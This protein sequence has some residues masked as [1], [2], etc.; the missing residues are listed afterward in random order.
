M[1]KLRRFSISVA[2]RGRY[3]HC[4][5]SFQSQL[6]MPISR[7]REAFLGN[8]IQVRRKASVA[9]ATAR[10]LLAEAQPIWGL[11]SVVGF[12]MGTSGSQSSRCTIPFH[13][14]HRQ[15]SIQWQYNTDVP[16]HA[17]GAE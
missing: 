14:S 10:L 1:H 6:E 4:K 9:R 3:K 7:V 11:P 15:T 5:E 12:A 13:E 16:F 8:K 17:A 2:V